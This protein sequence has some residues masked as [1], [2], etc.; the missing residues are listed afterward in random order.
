MENEMCLSEYALYSGAFWKT[1]G[2]FLENKVCILENTERLLENP[3]ILLSL[4]G[5]LLEYRGFL[6]ECTLEGVLALHGVVTRFH[7]YPQ[8]RGVWYITLSV[9]SMISFCILLYIILHY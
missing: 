6:L 2:V 4:G 8:M 5:C 7:P 9:Y 1:Y 3:G